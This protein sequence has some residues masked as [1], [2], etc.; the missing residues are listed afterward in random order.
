MYIRYEEVR[1]VH[2]ARSDVST[3]SFDFELELKSGTTLVFNSI[4]K[5]EYSRLF[6]FVSKKKLPIQNAKKVCR[7]GKQP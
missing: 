6:D 5:D 7:L 4:E 2:F 1:V 3:R